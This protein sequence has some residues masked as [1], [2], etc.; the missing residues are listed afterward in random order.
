M[1]AV[2]AAGVLAGGSGC[3][4][5]GSA[6]GDTD[7]AEDGSSG[8][9]TGST[10][11][12]GLPDMPGASCGDSPGR[13]GLQRLTRAEYNRTVRDLFGVTSNPADV[14][15]PEPTTDGFG[16]NASSLGVDPQMAALLLDVAETVAIEAMDGGAI[17]SC[18]ASAE[19]DCVSV[20]LR[21]LA[22][23]VY[24]RPP[25]D[26][27]LDGLSSF[28]SEA[29][30]AGDGV[31]VGLR[32]AVMAM[33][34]APQFL[35]RS[36]PPTSAQ[37]DAGDVVALDGYAVAT[38]LSYFLWGSTP[39]AELLLRAGDGSLSDPE[40]LRTQFDRM[41]ADP[42]ADAFF[43]GF[44]AQWLQ[45]GKL[46]DIAPDPEAFPTFGE[47][48]REAMADELRLFF[49]GVRSRDASVLEFVTGNETYVNAELAELYGIE[50]ITG[51]ELV[52]VT[53][54]PQQR[55]GVMTTPAVLAMTS[56]PDRTN[57]VKRGVWLAENILC[58]APPAPP[59]DVAPLP[60]AGPGETERE[61]LERHRTDPACASCHV[62]IDPLGFSLQGYDPLGRWR[63]EVD[64]EGVDDVGELPDGTSFSGA[65]ELAEAIGTHDRFGECVTEK[66]MTYAL[67]RAMASDDECRLEEIASMAATVDGTF[68]EF[69][70]TVVTSDAFMTEVAFEE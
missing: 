63:T 5:G 8:D 69:L 38:R 3:Q 64:G 18:E 43:E 2:F 36:V 27:E 67:G 61:R 66:M 51:A 37:A 41:L 46:Q 34:M 24:R 13:V 31:D 4:D 26:E 10:G 50:G 49:E 42:K 14:L 32:N 17:E 48:T 70:W 56:D 16:N 53:T 60:D 52:P 28:V 57:I 35:Y 9:E 29:E 12:P 39:D 15:P 25:T 59:P 20:A 23:R 33:L 47:D 54:D 6:S 21:G 44:V 40:G 65:I 1:R 7:G 68:S 11:D 58:A 62:L 55:A 45:L 30:A 22:L 19:S